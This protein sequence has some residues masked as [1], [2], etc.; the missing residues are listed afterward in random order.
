MY[1]V[2]LMKDAN[3]SLGFSILITQEGDREQD[4]SLK[5]VFVDTVTP[6][7]KGKLKPGDKILEVI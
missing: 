5:G 6:Q 1:E 2:E 7:V 4:E 3:D